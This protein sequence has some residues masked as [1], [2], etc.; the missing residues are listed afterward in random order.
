[1]QTEIRLRAALMEANRTVWPQILKT[2]VLGIAERCIPAPGTFTLAN[3]QIALP[4]N[5]TEAA[6]LHTAEY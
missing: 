1:M 2:P 5:H 3:K 4:L 6:F